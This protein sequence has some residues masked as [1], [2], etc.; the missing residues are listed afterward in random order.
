MR[1][2]F[3][4]LLLAALGSLCYAQTQSGNMSFQFDDLGG[5]FNFTLTSD[6][7]RPVQL[8]LE[9]EQNQPQISIF[10]NAPQW[11]KDVRR[12][13]I[14]FFGTLPFT[15]FFTRTIMSIFRMG[16]HNWDRRYAPWPFQPAGAVAM[17]SNDVLL[18]FCIAGSASLAISVADF[19]IV[20]NKRKAVN[21]E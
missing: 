19:F 2:S 15:V 8:N 10:E 5:C 4:L 9:T 20:R 1:R 17:T 16:Q 14:V 3:C 18:M 21:N 6:A 13:E 12:G 11:V 7:F